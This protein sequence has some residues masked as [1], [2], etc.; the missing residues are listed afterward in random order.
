MAPPLDL[1]LIGSGMAHPA[2]AAYTVSEL[3]PTAKLRLRLIGQMAAFDSRGSVP[4]PRVRKSRALLAILALASPQPVL[5]DHIT[6]LLWS[7]RE[8]EQA[9]ASLR[10]CVRD[11]QEMSA[12]WGVKLL[13]TERQHLRIDQDN[14]WVDVVALGRANASHAGALDMVQGNLLEDLVGL[15]P[16]FDQWLAVESRRMLDNA[17]RLASLVLDRQTEPVGI[18]AA[19]KRL[20]AIAPANEAGW[21]HLIA[22]HADAGEPAAAIE[23]FDQYALILSQTSGT[24]PSAETTAIASRLRAQEVT[25][26][27]DPG[28]YPPARPPHRHGFSETQASGPSGAWL[29]VAVFRATD[30]SDEANLSVGLA[31]EITT[32]LARFRWI[33]VIASGSIAALANEPPGQSERWRGLALDFLLDG[34]V[35]RGD[36]RIRV[37]VRLLDM[38]ARAGQG[39]SEVVWSARFERDAADLFSLQD[40]IAAETA[41]Q[42]DPELMARE[43]RRAASRPMRDA[44]AYELM[45]RAIP[46]IYRL[47]EPG[48]GEAGLLLEQAARRDP[49]DANIFAWW[50]CWHAFLVGQGWAKDAM[51]AMQRAGELA[52]R[53]VTLDPSCARALS[54]A[55]YVRSFVLHQDIAETIGLHDRALALN[56]NLPFAWAVSA[57]ALSYAG[58]HDAAV[59]RAQQARRLSP[60]DPHSFFFD[61]A[62]MVPR[63]MLREFEAVVTLGR[64]ALALNPSMSGT[65]KG[66]V[67]ALGHLGR[68]DEAHEVRT[69]LL[70][71][72]PGFCL[73]DAALRSPLRLDRDRATYLDG[74]RFAGLPE[75]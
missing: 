12:A 56:P 33:N 18:I 25:P 27:L 67:S 64:R 41:A 44:T 2:S 16:A 36:G 7:C 39:G 28:G 46:A 63:L 17:A 15:D 53:A 31:E 4:L 58:D 74:L 38:R 69:R 9:R 1:G 50:A 72:E 70:R 10:Q 23:A 20:V 34:S 68:I 13:R 21:R 40:E 60:F 73:K 19:A 51:A 75:S 30:P 61:N 11:L 66:L 32:A 14:L 37:N 65:C 59:Q 45:L 5:R 3:P 54:I 43:S 48:Y 6:S 8:K 71:I 52:E 62:L 22:A 47:T 26:G 57:L 55:G 29:G 35:Q 42:V 49:K 24:R